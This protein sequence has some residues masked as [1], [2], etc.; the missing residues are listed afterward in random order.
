M[1]K[2]G[3]LGSTGFTGEKLVEIL[4]GHPKVEVSY[5]GSRVKKAV[6]Y[7]DI[8]PKFA[9]KTKIKCQPFDVDKASSVCD[10]L[11]LSLPHTISMQFVPKVLKKGK[12]L[13]DLSADYRLSPS[14]YKTFY[15]KNHCDKDNLKKAIYGLPEIFKDKIKKAQ[16]IANPGCYPTSIILALYPL[17]AE[18]LITGKIVID[19]KSAVTGAGR[20]ALVDFHYSSVEN[21]F[22][23]YKPFVHQHQPEISQI[24]K[25]KANAK[26]NISFL[27]QVASFGAG[28]YS[29]IHLSFKKKETQKK[30]KKVYLKYYKDAP[31]IRVGDNLPKLKDVVGTNFL[32]IGFAVDRD[33]LNAVVV[34][35][36]DNLVKGAAGQAVQNMNIMLGFAETMGLT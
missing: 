3:V 2:V 7:S 23:A 25:N 31:F 19:S 4:L 14:L 12:K 32:D 36:I 5:I 13:I 1:I 8:F 28:I 10:F 33:G 30:I 11:F 9:K 29:T 26:I 24:I 22:W 34:S 20:K 17:W 21:N 6:L 15:K 16:L 27:P 35:S 18:N